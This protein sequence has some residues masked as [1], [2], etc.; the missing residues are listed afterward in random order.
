MMKIEMSDASELD[1]LMD[2]AAYEAYCQERGH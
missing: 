2:A 1:A